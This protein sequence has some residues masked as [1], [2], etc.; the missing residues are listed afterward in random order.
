MPQ[1]S[2][3]RLA[4]PVVTPSKFVLLTACALF[5]GVKLEAQYQG[6]QQFGLAGLKAGSM[7]APGLYVNLPIFWRNSDISLNGPQGNQVL[8]NLNF[9][10]NLFVLPA[11]EVV[12]PVKI[13]GATYG[14]SFTEWINNGVLN[15]AATGFQRATGYGFGDVYAQPAIL[16]WHTSHADV[17]AAYAFFAPTGSGSHGLHMW[18]N[19]IDFGTMFYPDAAKKWNL[20]TM[21]YYDFN[22]KKQGTDIKVGDILT[23]A[24][25][26]GHSF[27][28][29]AANAGA[30]YAAEWKI[31]RDSG[32]DIPPLL[33]LTNGR[34]FAVGPEIQFPLFEKGRNIG[35][36]G[37][38]YLWT[39]EPKTAFGGR[40][41]TASLTLARVIP[42]RQ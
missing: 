5:T 25:G 38:R 19:E 37:F 11:I 36:F 18:V 22:N 23:L 3:W 17:T 26:L 24:G 21:M 2:L 7:P 12:A 28:K 42:P 41:L 30:A 16:G 20:S 39:V 10:V 34:S 40:I 29:G 33:P 35:L 6:D 27:L 8:Q 14:A 4:I 32:A 1:A 15:V 31:T 9:D 13:L